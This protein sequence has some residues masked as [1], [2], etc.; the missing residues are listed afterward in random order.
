MSSK[1]DKQAPQMLVGRGGAAG[2]EALLTE[3]EMP[4]FSP[5]GGPRE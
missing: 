1:T 3:L 4:I 2:S 5:D